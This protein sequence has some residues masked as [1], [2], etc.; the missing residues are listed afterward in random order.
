LAA[1]P[2]LEVSPQFIAAKAAPT[3]TQP[4]L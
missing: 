4:F 1:I 3:G 2:A